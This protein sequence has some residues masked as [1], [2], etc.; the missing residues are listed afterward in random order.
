MVG[1][2]QKVYPHEFANWKILPAV[3]AEVAK[4][5]SAE[6]YTNKDIA[7]ILSAAPSCISQYINGSRGNGFQIPKSVDPML[8]EFVEILKGN[9]SDGILFYGITQICNE[10][11]RQ[12][13]AWD[14]LD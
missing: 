4:R 14:K 1:K 9:N 7:K 10:I 2:N 8:N 12:H 3:K 13:Y 6:G 5:L 11:M